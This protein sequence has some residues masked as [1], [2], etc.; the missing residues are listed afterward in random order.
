MNSTAGTPP[1]ERPCGRGFSLG[2]LTEAVRSCK[3][4]VNSGTKCSVK[5][6]QKPG[7]GNGST[8][9]E[10]D[11]NKLTPLPDIDQLSKIHI[12]MCTYVCACMLHIVC[13]YNTDEWVYE[14]CLYMCILCFYIH[15]CS[16]VC[17]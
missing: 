2:G 17:L 3:K 1:P 10:A 8:S 7:R 11:G 14:L 12:H 15:V 5:R 4:E 16:H 13:I 6:P 9:S